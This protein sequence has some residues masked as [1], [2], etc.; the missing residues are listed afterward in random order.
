[1]RTINE[2][3]QAEVL[4]CMSSMVSTLAGAYGTKVHD[5]GDSLGELVEQSFNLASPVPD[6][7]EAAIQEG[8]TGP[9]KDKFGATY[10][11]TGEE[12]EEGFISWAAAN[13]ESLCSD[14]NIEPYD[15]EVYEHWAVTA[16]FADKLIE[17]GE[18]VDKDFGGVCVWA[19][20][21]TGQVISMDYVVE[22]IHKALIA[23]RGWDVVEA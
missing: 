18:K 11:Q 9:H 16:W 7:E 3:V 4:C 15:R 23:P 10:F 17:H 13:W 1:M 19:R 6:Y 21:T 8:W 14:H 5:I 12:G 2:M 20:T 22:Q